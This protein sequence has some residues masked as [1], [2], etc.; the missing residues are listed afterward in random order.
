MELA[1]S[2]TSV[3][4]CVAGLTSVIRLVF[5]VAVGTSGLAEPVWIFIEAFGTSPALAI[6]R[7]CAVDAIDVTGHTSA[8][9]FKLSA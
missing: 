6:S 1:S 7:A 9:A 3:T 2:R 8:T 4:K 5:I